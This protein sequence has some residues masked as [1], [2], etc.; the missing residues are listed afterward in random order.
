[1]HIENMEKSIECVAEELQKQISGGSNDMVLMGGLADMLKDLNESLYHA[2][3]NKSMKDAE[4]EDELM[5]KLGIA[6][7]RRGYNGEN[8]M[9]ANRRRVQM[10][11]PYMH[12]RDMDREDAGRMYYGG[13]QQMYYDGDRRMYNG[14]N[15]SSMNSGNMSSG[16]SNSSSMR[17]Y[18]ESRYDRA[19][20]GYEEAKSMY[21]NNSAED[22]QAKM[23][24][25][26]KYMS[27]LS[28]D[29][30]D[31]IKDASPEE[32]EILRKKLN[33]LATKV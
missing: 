8:Y 28:M 16:S 27:E 33:T 4:E 2:K 20:R 23:R 15:G 19:R 18:S 11:E 30:T 24:E 9:R 14:G 17:G 6:D 5:S 13:S 29:M 10:S 31:M 32:K 7:D 26:E 12:Y 22:K 1:M 21:S 25:L 3:I